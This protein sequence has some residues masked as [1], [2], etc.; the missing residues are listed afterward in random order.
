[1]IQKTIPFFLFFVITL[2]H[3]SAEPG[4]W[5]FALETA[6]EAAVKKD[7]RFTAKSQLGLA[8]DLY[9]SYDFNDSWFLQTGIGYSIFRP[10]GAGSDWVSYRGFSS[11]Y[12]GAG[13]GIYFPSPAPSLNVLDRA[14]FEPGVTLRGFAGLG[15]YTYTDIYFF[16]PIIEVEPFV[17]VFSFFDDYLELRTGLPLS[18]NFQRDLDLF[19]TF[20]FSVSAVLYLPSYSTR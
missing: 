2:V 10:S 15:K 8:G 5:S 11:F 14:A 16:Y 9:L 20:G 12:F 4:N 3:L 6:P 13:L 19:F 18:W 1:M 7:A 17:R